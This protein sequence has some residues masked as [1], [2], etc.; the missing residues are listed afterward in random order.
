M[1][2]IHVTGAVHTEQDDKNSDARY[3]M[4]VVDLKDAETGK[5]GHISILHIW[6]NPI[7]EN[8]SESDD[9]RSAEYWDAQL[10]VC[11]KEYND[12]VQ[13]ADSALQPLFEAKQIRM[14]SD[15]WTQEQ[16]LKTLL[17]CFGN[18]H[19]VKNDI[20]KYL[21]GI[22]GNL[23]D[24]SGAGAHRRRKIKNWLQNDPADC[25]VAIANPD[26]FNEYNGLLWNQYNRVRTRE[27]YFDECKMSI[28][29]RKGNFW[30]CDH[31]GDV[32][33]SEVD[34]CGFYQ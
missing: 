21:G 14:S 4:T 10:K 27:K 18:A 29:T 24:F 11:V 16:L 23:S 5:Y 3:K 20:E 13:F 28:F 6:F 7:I 12:S 2:K 26:R 30:D 31:C 34:S 8:S 33:Q 1:N 15:N 22:W 9:D 19:N 25:E 32:I 17:G